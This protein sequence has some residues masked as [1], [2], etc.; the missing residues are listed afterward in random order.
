M[1]NWSLNITD[2]VLTVVPGG[3]TA[4]DWTTDGLRISSQKTQQQVAR[5]W[6]V[7]CGVSS[8]LSSLSLYP[9]LKPSHHM[10]IYIIYNYII[11]C[12]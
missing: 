6:A 1:K 4:N 8:L 2:L 5:L 10:V 9:Q 12:I 7:D 11:I 3:E